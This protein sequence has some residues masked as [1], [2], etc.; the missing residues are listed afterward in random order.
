MLAFDPTKRLDV[1]TALEHPY[2]GAYHDPADEPDCEVFDR[3]EE[4]ESLQT[5]E[6]LR[7]AL[8]QEIAEYRAEVR[9]LAQLEAGFDPS[10]DYEY[11]SEVEEGSTETETAEPEEMKEIHVDTTKTPESPSEWTG[12]PDVRTKLGIAAAGGRSPTLS[13]RRPRQQSHS[14]MAARTPRTP[15]TSGS[16]ASFGHSAASSRRPSRRSSSHNPRR[17]MSFLFGGG[18]TM[19]SLA[20][21][22]TNGP[23]ATAVATAS[24][25]ESANSTWT[26]GS[27]S[28]RR[29]RAPSGA[30]ASVTDM[31]SLRPLLRQLSTANLAE[32]KQA[33]AT[34]DEPLI[35]HSP[36][37]EGPIV[38][39]R[40]G[41][42][43]RRSTGSTG[44]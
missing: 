11:A 21:T 13:P 3:W 14:P 1:V 33:M 27:M 29:S 10:T 20:M 17:S 43:G 41:S 32:L 6:E 5:I 40:R 44:L 7:A 16:E 30:S 39:S 36:S 4:V 31:A 26:A 23:Q 19:S 24:S 42:R 38:M 2:V 22:S 37:G 35:T 15:A 28:G 12:S 18:M 34:D 8:T 25:A 9:G